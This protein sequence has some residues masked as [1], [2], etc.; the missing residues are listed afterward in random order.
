M[1]MIG[2]IFSIAV[3]AIPVII[4]VFC[5]I[6]PIVN[7]DKKTK[8]EQK[9]TNTNPIEDIKKSIDILNEIKLEEQSKGHYYKVKDIIKLIEFLE[10]QKKIMKDKD[11]NGYI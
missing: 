6:F 4:Y 7:N 11:N 5:L 1:L 3:F 10:E 8:Q 2:M 9:E